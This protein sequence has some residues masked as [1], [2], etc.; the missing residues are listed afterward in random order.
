MIVRL[1]VN[2][3][4]TPTSNEAT[5]DWRVMVFDK[6]VETPATIMETRNSPSQIRAIR[7]WFTAADRTFAT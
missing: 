5:T 2:K 4:I 6:K 3:V 7:G 1:I